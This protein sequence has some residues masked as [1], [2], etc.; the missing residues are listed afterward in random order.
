[1]WREGRKR[2]LR[3][4]DA[5]DSCCAFLSRGVDTCRARPPL[6]AVSHNLLTTEGSIMESRP[7]AEERVDGK[8]G[9][10]ITDSPP[11]PPSS[12]LPPRIALASLLGQAASSH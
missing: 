8:L 3:L 9:V 7:E 11:P 10:P 1:M 6:W 12:H 5:Q 2:T 4:Y